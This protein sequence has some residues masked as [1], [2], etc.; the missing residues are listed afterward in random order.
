MII[1][2]ADDDINILEPKHLDSLLS[3]MC[4]SVKSDAPLGASL[5][6]SIPDSKATANESCYSSST[7]ST[8]SSLSNSIRTNS[9]GISFFHTD[10]MPC[11]V[12]SSNIGPD[13]SFWPSHHSYSIPTP[14]TSY[15][16]SNGLFDKS[17]SSQASICPLG[18]NGG[19][20]TSN[21]ISS[22]RHCNNCNTVKTSK[23]Y[24]DHLDVGKY[25][26]KKCYNH[27]YKERNRF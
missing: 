21:R 13:S 15:N 11:R 12:A 25:I 10:A 27:R 18:G 17:Y 9:S 1:N 8:C 6:Q 19:N 20:P 24:K 26:C 7:S 23:W 2:G 5:W 3:S 4:H 22:D 16:S 14:S